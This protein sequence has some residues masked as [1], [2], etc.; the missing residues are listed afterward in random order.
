MTVF[1]SEYDSQSCKRVLKRLN[2]CVVAKVGQWTLNFTIHINCH[3]GR[4]YCFSLNGVSCCVIH[5][6][7]RKIARWSHCNAVA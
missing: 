2:A 5:I 7:I 6:N 3:V 4:L 1:C